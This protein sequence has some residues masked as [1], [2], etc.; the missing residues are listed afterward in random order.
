VISHSSSFY[1]ITTHLI[2]RIY[3]RKNPKDKRHPK[4][5]RDPCRSLAKNLTNLGI[6][7]QSTIKLD[8]KST[9]IRP[10]FGLQLVSMCSLFDLLLVDLFEFMSMSMSLTSS[11]PGR[12][13]LTFDFDF[14]QSNHLELR[15]RLSFDPSRLEFHYKEYKNPTF[16]HFL[17][18]LLK[19][20]DP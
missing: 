12:T 13:T 15:L 5:I 18:S 20:G 2:Y 11:L 9:T 14:M 1:R 19:S 17:F 3:S 10:S 7:L 4:T 8:Y 16:Y 6:L